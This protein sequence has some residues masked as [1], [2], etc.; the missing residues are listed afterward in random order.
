MSDEI[1]DIKARASTLVS[2]VIEEQGQGGAV[3]NADRERLIDA[4]EQDLG[5][6]SDAAALAKSD[7]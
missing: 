3:S 5:T 1:L 7:S 6:M 4:V 2:I